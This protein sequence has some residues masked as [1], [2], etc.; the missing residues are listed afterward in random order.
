MNISKLSDKLL[1]QFYNCIKE[2]L[3][4]DDSLLPTE[5]KKY[6]AREEPDWHEVANAI[7]MEFDKRDIKYSKINW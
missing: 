7:E 1:N 6:F 2:A 4:E 5:E 3:E